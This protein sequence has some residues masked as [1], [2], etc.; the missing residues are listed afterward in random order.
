MFKTVRQIFL[1]ILLLSLC[2][3]AVYSGPPDKE[4]VNFTDPLI[5]LEKDSLI[6][7]LDSIAYFNKFD[8]FDEFQFEFFD[9][10][11]MPSFPEIIIESDGIIK[12]MTDT[13]LVIIAIDELNSIL[14]QKLPEE[15]DLGSREITSWGKSIIIEEGERVHADVVV[16]SGDATIKGY[17]DGDVVVINGN[18]Y[19]ASSGYIRGDAIAIGGRVKKEE[20]AKITGSTIPF[21]AISL[22]QDYDS[23]YQVIQSILLLTI[24]I[25]LVLSVL[26]LSVFPRPINRIAGKLSDHPIKSFAFGYLVY[27][28]AFL[29]WLLLLVSVIGIPLAILGEPVILL[30]LLIISLTAINQIV[31]IKFFKKKGIF[32]SFWYGNLIMTGI[33]FVLLII[34]LATNSLVFFILNMILLGFLLFIILPLG[35][36][37][38]SLARF[39]FPPKAKKDDSSKPQISS[40]NSS[41]E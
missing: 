11:N 14:S 24:I 30:I 26:A 22:K 1:V 21:S 27:I 4:G 5:E 20:G 34:G 37:A 13:G 33:P 40:N 10:A 31:G 16:V 2:I 7:L 29:V 8:M 32:K 3:E 36:G 18:I 39:G 6:L 19:V 28:G 12:I 17:V 25:N 9:T 15:I 38:A 23:A 35:F 41:T